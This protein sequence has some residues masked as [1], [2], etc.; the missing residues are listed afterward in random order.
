A[1]SCY[2]HGISPAQPLRS[3]RQTSPSPRPDLVIP[4]RSPRDAPALFSCGL[5]VG[6]DASYCRNISDKHIPSR[7]D[8]PPVRPPFTLSVCLLLILFELVDTISG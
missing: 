2:D 8:P 3:T 1:R 7:D 5:S 4:H 6:H